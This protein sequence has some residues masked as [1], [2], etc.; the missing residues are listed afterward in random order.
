[1]HTFQRYGY[2]KEPGETLLEFAERIGQHD[3]SLGNPAAKFV[4]KYYDLAY[5]SGDRSEDLDL[6]M[7]EMRAYIKRKK[8]K[9][10]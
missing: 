4:K 1:M 8:G 9:K 3:L 5:G 6:I 2:D 10:P 7:K